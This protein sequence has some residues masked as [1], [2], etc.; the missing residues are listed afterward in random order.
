[1]VLLAACGNVACLLLADATRRRHEIAVRVAVGA[2]RAAVVGQLLAEGL[3]LALASAACAL[4][5]AH[6]AMDVLRRLA[7]DVPHAEVGI[8][9][10]LVLFT[11]ILGAFTTIAFA[12][13][14]ALQTTNIDPADALTRGGRGHVGGRHRLQQTLVAAQI[15]LAIVL[16]I[17]AGLLIRSFTRLAQVSP[18]FDPAGVTTF[19]MSASWSETTGSVVTRQARTVRRLE[20]IP[21]VE[22]AAVSQTL[23]AGIDIPPSEF[24]IAGRET[25]GKIFAQG[26]AVS[27]GYFRTLRIPILQ[28]DTCSADP[29]AP[30][31]SQALVTR[32]FADQYF[33]GENA[34]GHALRSPQLP[35][36]RQMTIVGIVGDVRE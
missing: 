24:S 17:G 25:P 6:W 1:L 7:A 8:D 3:L 4:V 36:D 31:F 11:M 9:G 12:L 27:S 10:R 21:G 33:G 20:E 16:L 28:G 32:A 5:F 14:P 2:S 34:I 13:A 15:A 29:A 18:G 26:R 35:P 23:P 22:A 30:L 19:R